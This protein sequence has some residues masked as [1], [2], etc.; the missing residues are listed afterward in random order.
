MFSL[1]ILICLNFRTSLVFWV[2]IF[3]LLSWLAIKR[4]ASLLYY[5]PRCLPDSN[6]LSWVETFHVVMCRIGI[7]E[8]TFTRNHGKQWKHCSAVTFLIYLSELCTWE[9]ESLWTEPYLTESFS[10]NITSYWSDCSLV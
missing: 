6:V 3:S 7:S 8:M 4:Q 10:L 9:R 2:L 1:W 5:Y